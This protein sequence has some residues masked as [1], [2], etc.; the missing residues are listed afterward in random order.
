MLASHVAAPVSFSSRLVCTVVVKLNLKSSWGNSCDNWRP[1]GPCHCHLF[2]MLE[3][4]AAS[5]DCKYI[6]TRISYLS[7]WRTP[8]KAGHH[9]AFDGPQP[10]GPTRLGAKT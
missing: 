7:A 2:Q 4:E 5:D 1:G 3:M 9:A 6:F 10:T 8:E